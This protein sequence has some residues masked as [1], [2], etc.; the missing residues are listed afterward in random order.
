MRAKCEYGIY[1]GDELLA[2][3]SAEFLQ[4]MYGLYAIQ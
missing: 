2:K 3:G 4:R 1:D